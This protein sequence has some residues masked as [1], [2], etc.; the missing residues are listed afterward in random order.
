MKEFWLWRFPSIQD[1]TFGV[2]L[3][4]NLPFCLT[5]E[6]PW[7]YNQKGISCYPD[8]DHICR[9]VQSPRFG[10]TFE[11]TNIHGRSECLFH[12][13]NIKDDSHGCTVL[14]EQYEYVF[15]E[16][17]GI[18]RNGVISTGKAFEEFLKRTEGIDEFSL[19]VRWIR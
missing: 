17:R 19:Y 1:G 15:V 12:K 5:L 16:K 2:L 9:R 13:G 14:G 6:L 18:G 10:N 8:G 4:D 7:V 3:D 11:I